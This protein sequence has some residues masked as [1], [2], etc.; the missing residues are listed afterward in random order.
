MQ[1]SIITA[2]GRVEP[3]LAD[4]AASIH[5]FV[6]LAGIREAE[7]II[8]C[9]VVDAEAVGALAGRSTDTV[10]VTVIGPDSTVNA[11]PARTRNRALAYATGAVIA[12]IDTDDM[13][14]PEGMAFMW[15]R[16]NASDGAWI[17][18]QMTKITE[19]GEQFEDPWE[20]HLQLGTQ[21][22]GVFQSYGREHGYVPWHCCATLVTA[23][24]VRAVGGWDES[25]TFARGEDVAMWARITNQH[26]GDW[27]LEPVLAK[28]TNPESITLRPDWG[29]DAA[30]EVIRLLGSS[31]D[32][33]E[34]S[35][36]SITENL[37]FSTS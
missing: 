28:R 14:M 17:A 37:N 5:R 29:T 16:F 8:A 21:N 1:L 27:C 18:G 12:T 30:T 11:G 25:A 26:R 4:T 36:G 34:P 19:A 2:A 15:E 22:L 7:W 6:E 31:L 24:A 20:I 10:K 32:V 9:D 33:V 23:S 35:R 13:F 3:Y